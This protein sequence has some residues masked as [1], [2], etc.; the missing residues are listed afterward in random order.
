M[1]L[2]DCQLDDEG[3]G[4][5]EMLRSSAGVS[6]GYVVLDEWSEEE[7]DYEKVDEELEKGEIVDYAKDAFRGVEVQQKM[8][9]VV[10]HGGSNRERNIYVLEE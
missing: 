1:L 2:M 8:Q 3:V 4:V 10:L 6:G 9:I 7:L 5:A